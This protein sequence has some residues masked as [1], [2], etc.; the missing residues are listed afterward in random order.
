MRRIHSLL[1]WIC[2]TIFLLIAEKGSAEPILPIYIEDNHAGSFYWLARNLNWSQKYQLILFDHHSDATAVFDSDSIRK[3]LDSG[4]NI[5]NFTS[6]KRKGIIQNYNWIE[7]LLPRPISRV[8]WVPANSLTLTAANTKKYEVAV[9]ISEHVEVAPRS[10]GDLSNTYTVRDFSAQRRIQNF[11]EPV[12][13]TIDLDYFVDTPDEQAEAAFAQVFDYILAIKQLNAITFS[14]SRPYLKSDAQADRLLFIALKYCTQVI[15]AKIYFEPFTSY[16]PDRSELAR[17]YYRNGKAIPYYDIRKASPQLISLFLQNQSRISV[18]EGRQKWKETLAAWSRKYRQPE[19]ILISKGRHFQGE[20][21]SALYY[22]DSF[23]IS[24]NVLARS[25]DGSIDWKAHSPSGTS[26]NIL[27]KSGFADND[28]RFVVFKEVELK[29][30][31]NRATIDSDQLADLFDN[32]TG[33]GTVRLFAE[34]TQKGIR[35]RSNEICISK[36]SG[37]D[38]PGRLTEIFNLPYI[39]GSGLLTINGLSGADAH[40]GADCLNFIIYGQRRLGSAIPYLNENNLRQYLVKVDDVLSF[41]DGVAYNKRG[42]VAIYSHMIL[43]GLL[44][45]FGTHIAA[46]YQ[47]NEPL[48]ILNDDDL[49]IHQLEGKAEIIK[50]KDLKQARQPFLLMKFRQDEH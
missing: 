38:Y 5:A 45:H 17:N 21:C 20:Y 28:P 10:E 29:G 19:L 46:L 25:N 49:V 23:T 14:I 2:L 43:N 30:L 35:A 4:D 3:T 50:L 41:H 34:V 8:T 11:A 24:L 7:P 18:V 37:L 22:K 9:N 33:F 26:Y 36:S 31:Q 16:G 32:R 1:T 12:I 13:V 40:F 47:D 15:N 6:W 42:R 48:G 44:L 39:L 27:G